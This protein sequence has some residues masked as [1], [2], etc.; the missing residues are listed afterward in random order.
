M[1]LEKDKLLWKQKDI[2]ST[3]NKHYGSITDSLNLFSW[4]GDTSMSSENDTINSVIKKFI[5]HPSIK[6]IKKKFKIKSE[7]LF[8]LVSTETINRII[9]D[10]DIKKAS[11]GEIPTYAILFWTLSQYEA[12]ETASFT[13]SLKCANV[14]PIYKKEEPFDKKNYRPVRILPLL[15]KI[16]ERVIYEQAS[17]Y[18]EPF[19]NEILCGFI[20][21]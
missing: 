19:S 13:D 14:R 6:A 11:S 12:L 20:S 4:P 21:T 8:N 5:F 2:T 15:S 17:N 18:F 7:F 1:L 10:L 16:Y 3:F 9:N